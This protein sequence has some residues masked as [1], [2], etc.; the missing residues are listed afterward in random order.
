MHQILKLMVSL[1]QMIIVCTNTV[2]Q[3]FFQEIN[4]DRL[5]NFIC[6]IFTQVPRN[7]IKKFIGKFYLYIF[8]D[9]FLN[10]IH[11]DHFDPTWS[12]MY[13]LP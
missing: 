5:Q 2:Y 10:L 6:K 11:K 7:L 12:E 9:F 1:F 8:G 3:Y 13:H 4:V